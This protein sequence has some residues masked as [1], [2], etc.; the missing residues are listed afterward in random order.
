MEER[1]LLITPTRTCNRFE[2][3]GTARHVGGGRFQF[4]VL[5]S[6]FETNLKN[7]TVLYAVGQQGA[8]PN[9]RWQLG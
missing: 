8:I 2:A 7:D 3:K 5:W 9:L 1:G 6:I 4:L